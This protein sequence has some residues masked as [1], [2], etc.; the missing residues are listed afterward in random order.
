MLTLSSMPTAIL[1]EDIPLISG[2]QDAETSAIF[3]KS[4]QFPNYFGEN[5]NAWDECACDL[6]WLMFSSIAIVIDNYDRMFR[7]TKHPSDEKRHFEE[8]LSRMHEYWT[9]EAKVPCEITIFSEQGK[10]D[11]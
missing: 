3:S 9:E 2:V 11:N 8:C 5:W 1:R 4:I 7:L 6:D 10:Y